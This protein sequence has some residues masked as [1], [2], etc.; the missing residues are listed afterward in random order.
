MNAMY[1]KRVP[2]RQYILPSKVKAAEQNCPCPN[3][4]GDR[5]WA[6]PASKGTNC[7]E[8]DQGLLKVENALASPSEQPAEIQCFYIFDK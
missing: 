6:K 5:K 7:K 4:V 2:K 8:K 3:W 1:R